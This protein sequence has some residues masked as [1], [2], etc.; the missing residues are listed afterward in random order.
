MPA[1][2]TI[3]KSENVYQISSVTKEGFY[4]L[5][6]KI[7]SHLKIGPTFFPDDFYTK[8]SMNFRISEIIREKV[9]ENTREEIPHSTFI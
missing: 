2:I 3:P 7:Q 6:Q 5:V 1:K 8:Q 4:E 9:F